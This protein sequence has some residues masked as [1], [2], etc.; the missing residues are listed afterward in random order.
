MFEA[1]TGPKTLIDL[2]E[3]GCAQKGVS[4]LKGEWVCRMVFVIGAHKAVNAQSKVIAGLAH[5]IGN[6][7]F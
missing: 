6:N 1:S 5:D 2:L 4:I 3:L 7:I